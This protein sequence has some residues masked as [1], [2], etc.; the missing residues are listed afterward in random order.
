MSGNPEI[1]KAIKNIVLR[2][3]AYEKVLLRLYP[4]LHTCCEFPHKNVTFS[5]SHKIKCPNCSKYVLSKRYTD[6]LGR[7]VKKNLNKV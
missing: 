7:C 1:I 3:Y 4:E 5:T 6:H 2:N